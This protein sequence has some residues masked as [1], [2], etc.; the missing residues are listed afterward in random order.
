M[1]CKLVTTVAHHSE[2]HG[3]DIWNL[4]TSELEKGCRVEMF[5]SHKR[6][7]CIFFHLEIIST[8]IIH[9]ACP[10]AN[11]FWFCFQT[12]QL[13]NEATSSDHHK[14]AWKTNSAGQVFTK[15]QCQDQ[16]QEQDSCDTV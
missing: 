7:Q 13:L 1:Q 12:Q 14:I 2:Y 9:I 3:Q 8:I 11:A 15:E 6:G 10:R 5:I 16:K 4:D